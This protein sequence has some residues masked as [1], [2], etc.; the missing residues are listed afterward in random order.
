MQYKDY[1]KA[2]G[3][4]KKADQDTIKK[5][6]RKLAKEYHPDKHPNDTKTVEKFK[7]INEAYEV[8]GNPDKRKKYDQLS[9]RAERRSGGEFDPSDFGFN[10]SSYGGGQRYQSSSGFSDFFEAFFGEQSHINLDD[11]F[12]GGQF[13]STGQFHSNSHFT[14]ENSNRGYAAADVEAELILNPKEAYEGVEKKFK[15]RIGQHDRTLSVK[16]PP[17]IMTGEKIKLKGQ[18]QTIRSDG[19][20]G[21]L[22]L[23][24]KI[25]DTNDIKL[26]GLDIVMVVPITPW[27]AAL[28][29]EI[30]VNAFSGAVKL[31]VP[32]G[33][34][35]G[36]RF[37]LTKKGYKNRKGE[38][39]DLYI[40]TKM[41]V[42]PNLKEEEK[43]LLLKWKALSSYRPNR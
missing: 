42:P 11:L 37:R 35:S 17:G 5:A 33:T 10:H 20:S 19:V 12:G 43:E 13:G 3:V 14:R 39:G 22:Y 18:G 32:P 36:K 26:D 25:M 6:Y 31:K 7:E 16:I 34:G 4:D 9:S 38:R 15:I 28:G 27:E 30:R 29:G 2:L 21:D 23:H 8:L 1:Y 24:I 40:E 41:V